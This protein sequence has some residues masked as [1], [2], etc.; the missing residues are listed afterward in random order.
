MVPGDQKNEVVQA[1]F[2]KC[3]KEGYVD[4][5][6]MKT[7]KLAADQDIFHSLLD[8]T[9]DKTGRVDFNSAPSEWS[10]NMKK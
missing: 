2:N 6:V 10:R 4:I 8:E 9:K 1:L 7:L 3:K 5:T